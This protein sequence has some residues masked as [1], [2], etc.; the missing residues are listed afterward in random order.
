MKKLLPKS[1][2][3]VK[4]I[5]FFSYS[6]LIYGIILFS[7]CAKESSEKINS[8]GHDTNFVTKSEAQDFA[9]T[10]VVFNQH[11]PGK[12]SAGA[13]RN[14]AEEA[15]ELVEVGGQTPSYY[16]I[17]YAKGGFVII[18]ADKR[19]DPVLAFSETN[20]FN[21]QA[22]NISSGL[23]GWLA[24]TDDAISNLR[25]GTVKIEKQISLKNK[26]MWTSDQ[27]MIIDPDPDP[28]EI[29][30][31]TQEGMYS[32]ESTTKGPFLTTTWGQNNGFNAYSP[33]IGCTSGQLPPTGCVATSMAQILRY[34]Q[35][36]SSYNWASM[37]DYYATSEAARLMRDAG[38]AV[39]MDYG[40][41]GSSAKTEKA[42]NAFVNYFGYT[43]AQYQDYN[44]QVVKSE[45]NANRPVI[46][47]GGRNDQWFI[48]GRYTDGHAWVCDGLW[49]VSTYQCRKTNS[50]YF[51]QP[52][53][54][55]QF[56][57]SSLYFNMNWGWQGSNDGYYAF[58]NFNPSTN[59]FNY[60]PG[61]ITNIRP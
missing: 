56:V 48:F 32:Y 21:L 22:K 10:R 41:D 18:A 17:N 26:V 35:K 7:S 52:I 19:L 16:I 31:C 51:P 9:R 54:Q 49:E 29:A 61:M 3:L 53:L 42:A 58:N 11:H 50:P 55:K 57:S 8:T 27:K 46:L 37:S 39:N 24:N 14:L 45:I 36:P 28:S 13:D 47:S 20:R 6:M 30:N 34:Y 1:S 12:M 59:T 40:C 15:L 25:K 4:Q 60:K 33:N 5:N 44:Y 23:V 2:F 38:S 43:S